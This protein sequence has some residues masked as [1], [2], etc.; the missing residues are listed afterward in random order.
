MPVIAIVVKCKKCGA[1]IRSDWEF[2]PGCGDKMVCTGKYEV[3]A[4]K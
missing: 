3:C 4:N 2:C 1:E